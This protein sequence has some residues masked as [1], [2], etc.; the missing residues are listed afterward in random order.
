MAGS[1]NVLGVGMSVGG[2][3]TRPES[4]T[5][6]ALPARTPTC[7]KGYVTDLS[8]LPDLTFQNEEGHAAP[9]HLPRT[10]LGRSRDGV[11]VQLPR[12]SGRVV[13]RHVI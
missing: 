5:N 8:Y 2:R 3:E 6:K 1:G 4:C 10:S 11:S 7:A 12:P 13:P 9:A